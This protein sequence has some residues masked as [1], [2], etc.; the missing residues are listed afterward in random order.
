M[1]RPSIK[2]ERR[3]QILLAFEA[4]AARYGLEGA[5]LERIAEEAGLARALIRHNVGNKEDLTEA[6]VERFLTRSKAVNKAMLVALPETQRALALTDMLFDPAHV[7]TQFMLLCEALIAAA[8]D[9]PGLAKK[10]RQWTVD[11][12]SMVEGVIKSDYPK[13]KKTQIAAVAAGVTGIYFNV[14]SLTPLG[15]MPKLEKSSRQAAQ[16][17]IESLEV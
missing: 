3:E 1:A 7:D 11:F 8:A 5:T 13:A 9:N 17:L 14:T 12:V 4:C 6:L 2:D 10:M 15:S 16:L